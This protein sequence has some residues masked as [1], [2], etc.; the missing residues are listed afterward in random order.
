M[1]GPV[2]DCL[3]GWVIGTIHQTMQDLN[4]AVEKVTSGPAKIL[5]IDAGIIRKG[6]SADLCIIKKE[7][8]LRETTFVDPI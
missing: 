2:I 4:T 8:S 6:S 5:G 3:T 1:L 7:K